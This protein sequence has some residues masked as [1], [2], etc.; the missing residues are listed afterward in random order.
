MDKDLLRLV[1]LGM[2]GVLI[3]GIILWGYLANRKS[4]RSVNFYDQRNPLDHIDE[5][6]IIKTGDDDFDIVPLGSAVAQETDE[7]DLDVDDVDLGFDEIDQ[8]VQ[9]SHHQK[10][11][12]P[13][14]IQF[15]I[16]AKSDEGFNGKELADSFKAVG[17][18]HTE[19]EIFQRLDAKGLP[20]YA[21]ASMVEPGTFPKDGMDDFSCP[22]IVFFM[23]PSE[24]DNS[25]EVYDEM[26]N[27]INHLA[28]VLDGIEWDGD[29]QPLTIET[30]QAIR[31]KLSG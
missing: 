30:V 6:L 28:L 10:V 9:Q 11:S 17:L 23:Q 15:S 22:G 8:P 26:I 1:I 16:V 25:L 14:I 12:I 27:S 5:S 7:F 19:L 3:V 29:R 2:G 20:D 13:G 18:Q 31:E 4:Q 21:V 24:L